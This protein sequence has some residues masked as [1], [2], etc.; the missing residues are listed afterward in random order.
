MT[1]GR[2][3]HG[4]VEVHIVNVEPHRARDHRL[5][6]N[7]CDA[8]GTSYLSEKIMPVAAI[9]KAGTHRIR[10]NS[11]LSGILQN[12]RGR[13]GHRRPFCYRIPEPLLCESIV[14]VKLQR[15]AE[16]RQ[17][18]CLASLREG[19]VSFLYV[20]KCELLTR[21]LTGCHKV[22][23]VGSQKR[24]FVECREGF[25][26]MLGM[27]QLQA[28]GKCGPRLFCL[29]L[30]GKTPI[31]VLALAARNQKNRGSGLMGSGWTRS[32]TER[33]SSESHGH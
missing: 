12:F 15:T 21:Q 8:K 30:G 17:G 29:F 14:R 4:T 3:L 13:R 16:V 26:H 11:K 2:G 28:G 6:E 20:V 7:G 23:V 25:L 24:R 31:D 27:L 18:F 1:R 32:L 19:G 22:H 33:H 9:M 5:V 10:L